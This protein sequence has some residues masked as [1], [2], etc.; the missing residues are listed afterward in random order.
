MMSF[1]KI[2]HQL[3]SGKK[4]ATQQWVWFIGLYLIGFITLTTSAYFLKGLISFL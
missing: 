4:N 1:S 2:K 3:L